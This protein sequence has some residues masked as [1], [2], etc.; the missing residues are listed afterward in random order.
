MPSFTLLFGEDGRLLEI[1]R[2][3]GFSPREDL[4]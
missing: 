2:I 4:P 1:V 3:N